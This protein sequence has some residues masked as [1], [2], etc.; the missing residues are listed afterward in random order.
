[1]GEPDDTLQMIHRFDR[2]QRFRLGA[3]GY[4]DEGEMCTNAF[5][6]KISV[7]EN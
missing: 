2:G 6:A 4:W 5:L 3:S 7:E 1:M